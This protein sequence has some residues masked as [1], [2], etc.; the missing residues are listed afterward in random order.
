MPKGKITIIDDTKDINQNIEILNNNNNKTVKTISS[1]NI[2]TMKYNN[3][4]IIDDEN[5]ETLKPEKTINKTVK[6]EKTIN[7]T[8]VETL[9][10]VKAISSKNDETINNENKQI[11]E[12]LKPEKTINKTVKYNNITIIDDDNDEILNKDDKQ[13]I[14]PVKL[15]DDEIEIKNGNETIIVKKIKCDDIINHY[16]SKDGRIFNSKLQE[17]KTYLKNGYFNTSIVK[18]MYAV[19]RLVAFT[20]ID[21]PNNYDVV[22]HIDENKTNNNVN[23]LE[24]VTQKQNCNAHNKKISHERKVIQKDIDG[25]I[26]K[27]HVSVTE[28]A[29]S[30]ELS[31]SAVTK[32]CN[33]RN[34][35]AGKFL[36]EYE[37]KK[38]N[39]NTDVDLSKGK[40]II[41]YENYYVFSDGKIYNTQRKAFMKDCI[42]AHGSHYITLSYGNNK[43]V[44]NLVATYF[45]DNPNNCSR[46]RHIDEKNKGNNDVSNLEW[47]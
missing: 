28:A 9:K 6:P 35:S 39:Y 33:G 8:I 36:W 19:H 30:I 5:D 16:I 23:N 20:Y 4:I 47:Y 14:E 18:K 44:H 17:K 46:V 27:I 1:K 15:E 21:N 13:I 40:Q 42:N 43:Y 41:N 34:K 10:P 38:Y 32:A 24:W 37:D 45:L 11:I 12:T 22:N 7:K 25:N 31:R 3:I 26:I 29:K 2:E